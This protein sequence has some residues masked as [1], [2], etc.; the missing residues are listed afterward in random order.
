MRFPESLFARQPVRLLM[1]R[2]VRVPVRESGSHP[3]SP[4]K[5]R[6]LLRH[7][8]RPREVLLRSGHPRQALPPRETLQRRQ[9][10]RVH[11]H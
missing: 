11:P 4:F 9:L 5:R 1:T 3:D 8:D 6:R 10:R 2:L 7:P